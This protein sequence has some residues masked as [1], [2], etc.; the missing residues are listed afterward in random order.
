M[1]DAVRAALGVAGVREPVEVSVLLT[2]DAT[3]RAMNRRYRGKDTPTDVLAF[4]QAEARRGP[5]PRLLGDVV[6]SLDRA[7]E[8]AAQAGHRLADEIALLAVH[9][10]LHLLGFEDD[11]EA[12]RRRMWEA[13][14]E[15]LRR[16]RPA[17][18]TSVGE[19]APRTGRHG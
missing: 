11:T 16:L 18:R 7:A 10:T 13:Q 2:D 5:G 14:G 15:I 9:G 6:I 12:G 17:R 1:R 3:I 19:G 8:Q 4:P